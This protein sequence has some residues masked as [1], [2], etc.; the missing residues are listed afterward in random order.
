MEQY[1]P[2]CEAMSGAGDQSN[3]NTCKNREL[4]AR[5]AEEC[6]LRS[7]LTTLKTRPVEQPVE[8]L[9]AVDFIATTEELIRR[10][11]GFVPNRI[12]QDATQFL[13]RCSLDFRASPSDDERITKHRGLLSD[14][15]ACRRRV[16]D[17][18][19]DGEYMA[20]FF[21]TRCGI[22]VQVRKIFVMI[23]ECTR[24]QLKLHND[25][26][27]YRLFHAPSLLENS[28]G[29]TVNT[30]SV[31]VTDN[32]VNLRRN[33]AGKTCP[34]K[35]DVRKEFVTTMLHAHKRGLYAIR[36]WENFKKAVQVH[37]TKRVQSGKCFLTYDV[38]GE[39]IIVNI[40]EIAGCKAACSLMGSHPDFYNC[41]NL[42]K[43]RPH[44]RI[45][46]IPG[47]FPHRVDYIDGLGNVS[48]VCKSNLVPVVV[49]LAI[50]GSVRD[51]VVPATNIPKLGRGW[52][53]NG[54]TG[55]AVSREDRLAYY[56]ELCEIDYRTFHLETVSN[57][58]YLVHLGSELF[59][60][61][62]L[63][64]KVELV[65]SDTHKP[66][67]DSVYEPLKVSRTYAKRSNCLNMYTSKDGVPYPAYC[68]F[69]AMKLTTN[70][71]L[72]MYKFK[73]TAT[74]MVKASVNRPSYR[75]E[76]VTYSRAFA[77][78]STK[79]AFKRKLANSE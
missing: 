77:S 23:N 38:L 41:D 54:W 44:L 61:G 67:D 36:L 35:Y 11:R 12:R 79:R 58:R 50:T 48:I 43:L 72:K 29:A 8:Q 6:V 71:R 73:V 66:V 49:D 62:G 64:C 17:S 30:L 4:C 46:T 27:K 10:L 40:A 57:D 78:A 76:L 18:E 28:S 25:V 9:D 37:V 68:W 7:M 59:F 63:S 53:D 33:L 13:G 31:N 5:A 52:F 56:K 47:S 65:Y 75:Q 42:K 39:D 20:P 16:H 22:A 55:P 34:M 21:G 26:I 74:G 19:H 32:L 69:H 14:A 2:V 1:Q 51:G 15:F 60:E 24:D 45:R 3:R 70:D